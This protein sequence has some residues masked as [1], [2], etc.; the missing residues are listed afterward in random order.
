[1][2]YHAEFDRGWS[3]G[4]SVYIR[5]HENGPLLPRLSWS[6][7]VIG[8]DMSRP[9]TIPIYV[10]KGLYLVPF[11]RYIARNSPKIATVS[12]SR[13]FNSPL[14]GSWNLVS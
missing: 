13:V 10:T 12:Y 8:D 1:M 7:E 3:N 11:P 5:P 14:R 6:L 2:G 9:V 4:T